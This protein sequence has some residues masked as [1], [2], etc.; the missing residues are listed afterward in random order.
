[1]VFG[2][3]LKAL[4]E[5]QVIEKC[6]AA[7]ADHQRMLIGVVNAAKV[8]NLRRDPLLRDSLLECDLIVADGQSVVWA[9]RLVNQPLPERVAGCNLFESLL[10]VAEQDGR[11]VFL[12]GAKPEVLDLLKSRLA[13]RFPALRIAGSRDGY[14]TAEQQGEVAEEIKKSHADMLFLGITSPKKEIFLGKYGASLGVPVMH[15]VGGSF[16]VVAGI[17]KRAPERWQRMGLEWAYR[18]VQEP[19]R[20]WKRYLTTNTKFMILLGREM[21]QPSPELKPTRA[22]K[23]VLPAPRMPVNRPF[24]RVASPAGVGRLSAT[25]V[26]VPT[27]RRPVSVPAKAVQLSS[28]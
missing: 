19:R 23:V 18:T 20:M 21:I 7:V 11:S 27:Q 22:L 10:A 28:N 5:E 15:G 2:L 26:V 4:T 24:P 16:D 17:T 1:M 12:L 14:F 9:S 25:A 8:V 13:E 6:R 3:R